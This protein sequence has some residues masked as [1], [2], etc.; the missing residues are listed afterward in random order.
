MKESEKVTIR[1][2]GAQNSTNPGVSPSLVGGLSSSLQG[3]TPTTSLPP[4]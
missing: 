3:T 4:K 1:T 2:M